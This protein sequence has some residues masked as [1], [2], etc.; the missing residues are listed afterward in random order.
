MCMENEKELDNSNKIIKGY[1]D[2]ICDNE[3]KNDILD[4][5]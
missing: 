5:V 1:E 4:K 3:I 2:S